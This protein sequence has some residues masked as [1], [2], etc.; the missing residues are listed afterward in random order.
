[1]HRVR[2][3][4]LWIMM[5]A[6]PLQGYAAAAMV[7][8]GLGHAGAMTEMSTDLSGGGAHA[9]HPHA[10]GSG[11][12]HRVASQATKPPAKDSIA[13]TASAEPD[14]MHKCGTCGACH[15]AALTSMLEVAVFHDLP[16]AD[17][18]EPAIT[19]AT[20]TPR[21]LDKPPRS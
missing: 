5:F 13:K 12:H 17:L 15:A 19:V 4:V 9:Q 20:L 11:D 16:R 6:V 21:V 18:A 10:D 1:M 7:F 8:C 2:L 14:A 3:F